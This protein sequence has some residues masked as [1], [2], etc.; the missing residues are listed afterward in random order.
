[1]DLVVREVALEVAARNDGVVQPLPCDP[2]AGIGAGRVAS[3]STAVNDADCDADAKADCDADANADCDADANAV[4]DAI[5]DCNADA[6]ANANHHADR[7]D[8]K[9]HRLCFIMVR[10]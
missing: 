10:I 7:D 9:H 8:P 5:A 6:N 2:M 3:D 4:G 1:M